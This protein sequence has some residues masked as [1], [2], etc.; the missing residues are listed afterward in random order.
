MTSINKYN[1]FENGIFVDQMTPQD[2]MFQLITEIRPV[3]TQFELIRLGAEYDGGY[4]LPNDLDNIGVCFSPGV[5]DIANFESDIKLKYGIESHLADFSVDNPPIGF[6]PKSFTKKFIGPSDNDEYITISSWLNQT[7]ETESNKDLLLQMDIEG[8]EYLSILSTPDELIKKFRII[9]IEIH[10]IEDWGHKK[11]FN[12]VENFFSK[13]LKNYYVVH[14]HPNNCCGLVNMNGLIAPRVF[15][16]TLLRK[17][18]AK[19][20]GYV[21][22]FPHALDKPNLKDRADLILPKNWW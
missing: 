17:D 22:N 20:A 10:N 5:D 1:L 6:K 3:K 14:N 16:L 4:L 12:M 7:N 19:F 15:E 11:Y 9:V 18:R 21:E 13:L 8:G 2:K